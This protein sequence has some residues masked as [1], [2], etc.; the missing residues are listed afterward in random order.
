M[1]WNFWFSFPSSCSPNVK[2]TP[3]PPIPQDSGSPSNWP[4]GSLISVEVFTPFSPSPSASLLS[5]LQNHNSP[6]LGQLITFDKWLANAFLILIPELFISEASLCLQHLLNYC[7][8]N[9]VCWVMPRSYFESCLEDKLY[10]LLDII[11]SCIMEERQQCTLGIQRRRLYCWLRSICS[12]KMMP[13]SFSIIFS[14]TN[15][16]PGP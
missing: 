9:E 7:L 3:Q 10:P 6:E 1:S 13:V 2:C 8:L 4:A 5:T 15:K 11:K 12:V 16:M 14:E